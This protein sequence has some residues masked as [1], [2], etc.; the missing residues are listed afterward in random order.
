MAT[1]KK[2]FYEILA[3]SPN[4]SQQEIQASHDSLIIALKSQQ[5]LFKPE[6]YDS[7][8]KMIA[9]AFNMLS[10]PASRD[11]YDAELAA[12]RETRP[13]ASASKALTLRP[14]AETL[15]LKAEALALRAEAMS[16]RADAL[17]MKSDIGAFSNFGNYQGPGASASAGPMSFLKKFA[18]FL[19][20][21]AAAWMVI[22]VL[23]LLV[24]NRN[25]GG[26]SEMAARAE[27]KMIIQEYY[28]T[29]GVRAK[30]RA[31]VELLQAEERRKSEE[32]RQIEREAYKAERDKE[33]AEA[34]A[35]RFEEEARQRADQVSAELRYAENKAREQA[36]REEAQ[37]IWKQEEEK[38]KIEQA[39]RYRIEREKEKWRETL[40]R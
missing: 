4:A 28:Q 38:R 22:Q 30:N 6:D 32:N 17:S 33:K 27:E 7:K 14:D 26:N 21:L 2:T 15:S 11:A 23:F 18:M 10:I 3:I 31:E 5:K 13:D 16:L 35:R 1:K 20:F 24:F 34:A 9:L 12:N 19:G 29:H 40:R 37:K 39:E 8:L 36:E 25:T